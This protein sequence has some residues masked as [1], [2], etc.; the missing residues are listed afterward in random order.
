MK[1]SALWQETL[2]F[3]EPLVLPLFEGVLRVPEGVPKGLLGLPKEAATL[4]EWR[5]TG[6]RLAH[7]RHRLYWQLGDW[8]AQRDR[9]GERK[10]LGR[11][12]AEVV[13]QLG[14]SMKTLQNLASLSRA[15]P[16]SE[17][18]EGLSPK[19]HEVALALR[20]EERRAFLLEAKRRGWT[21]RQMAAEVRRRTG[22]VPSEEE[23]RQPPLFRTLLREVEGSL[24]EGF[25]HP[26]YRQSRV[27]F[28]GDRI[29]LWEPSAWLTPEAARALAA[30]LLR[31]AEALDQT[32]S[33]SSGT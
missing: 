12:A 2:G 25:G 11:V 7:D 23:K 18:V 4:K 28:R 27:V 6:L 16:P 24:E 14:L 5:A 21:I 26:R 20:P 33:R 19:A 31:A 8:W 9:F 13:A 1:G 32:P 30:S 10:R 17:R 15:Y 29:L 22:R 3:G